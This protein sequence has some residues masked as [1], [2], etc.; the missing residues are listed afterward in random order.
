MP[1]YELIRSTTAHYPY[2]FDT[3]QESPC[4]SPAS[5][6]L[7]PTRCPLVM[8]NMQLSIDWAAVSCLNGQLTSCCV[9]LVALFDSEDVG[10]FVE[11]ERLPHRTNPLCGRRLPAVLFKGLSLTYFSAN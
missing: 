7:S 9:S 6:S 1:S 2:Q 11:T 3:P 5:L 10:D 4:F 8:P